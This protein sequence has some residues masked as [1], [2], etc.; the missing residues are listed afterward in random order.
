[1]LDS[2]FCAFL[3]LLFFFLSIWLFQSQYDGMLVYDCKAVDPNSGA[4]GIIDYSFNIQ[5]RGRPTLS[6]NTAEF[7]INPVTCIIRA[8]IVYDREQVDSYVVSITSS[9]L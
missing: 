1:M 9:N 4:A 8:Q 5:V 7:R 2:V 3:N 6:E